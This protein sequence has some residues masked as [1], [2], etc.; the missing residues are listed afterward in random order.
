M[1]NFKKNKKENKKEVKPKEEAKPKEE[2]PKKEAKLKKEVKKIDFYGKR[3][4]AVVSIE[5]KEVNEILYNEV[6][7]I[8]GTTTLVSDKELGQSLNLK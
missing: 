3:K 4:I 7:L 6:K 2:I 5:K 8:D 1:F